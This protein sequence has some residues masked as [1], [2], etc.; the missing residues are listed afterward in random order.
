MGRSAP[1]LPALLIAACAGGGP[2]TPRDARSERL[3]SLAGMTERCGVPARTLIPIGS[4]QVTMQVD[5]DVEWGKVECLIYEIKKAEPKLRYTFTG[6][7]PYDT[8]NQQ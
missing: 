3:A 5:P 2:D 7:A 4:D 6:N 8:G 1:L